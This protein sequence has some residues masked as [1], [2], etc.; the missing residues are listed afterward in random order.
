MEI[1]KF[2][3]VAKFN[4]KRFC[5]FTSEHYSVYILEILDNN[6]L[7]YPQYE[8][9]IGFFNKFQKISSGKIRFQLKE[10][11]DSK[12]GKINKKLPTNKKISFIPK[13]IKD[14]ILI[15]AITALFLSGCAYPSNA[16]SSNNI[17]E[18]ESIVLNI[19]RAKDAGFDIEYQSDLGRY[20]TKSYIESDTGNK[21]I[22]CTTNDELKSYFPDENQNPKY[23]DVINTIQ[24]NPN[25]P[26]KI[27]EQYIIALQKM[28]EVMPEVDLFLLNLNA[29]RMVV[30][31]RD[32]LSA[33]LTGYFESD[34]GRIYYI[35]EATNNAIIH[36]LS[37]AL[38]SGS[39]WIGNNVKIEKN[40]RIPETKWTHNSDDSNDYYYTNLHASMAE[41]YVAD[42]LG[43]IL[44]GESMR[45]TLPYTPT[46][47]HF[48][49]Y[50]LACNYSLQ[51]LINDG[52]IGF[53]K[54]MTEN[55]I[56]SPIAFMDDEDHLMSRYNIFDYDAKYPRYGVTINSIPV[57]F[58]KDWAEEKFERKEEGIVERAS[59]CINGT[60]FTD[61][62]SY[63]YKSA[64]G[65][66][67]VDSSTPQELTQLVQESLSKLNKNPSIT[68]FFEDLLR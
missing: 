52:P 41:E 38:L 7:S 19:D 44:T 11:E 20:I 34:T 13:V 32:K 53:A 6:K 10:E 28:K 24:Q 59:E 26:D 37:H 68:D 16:N 56:N 49:M 61:G 43:E 50:R 36:E 51:N 4:G 39:F 30:V 63:V 67:T 40:F 29:K 2:M 9:Y 57:E 12:N 35:K 33:N 48:E 8:D 18:G 27:K 58:F 55:D 14:G 62:V 25:I 45:S 22:I 3:Y 23:D 46:D 31:E 65:D 21:I 1:F 17:A 5:V 54:A 66:K 42:K 60:S 47:Y 15:T 64:E